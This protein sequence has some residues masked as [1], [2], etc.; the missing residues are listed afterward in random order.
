MTDEEIKQIEADLDELYN[1][2]KQL[3]PLTRYMYENN[4]EYIRFFGKIFG[5]NSYM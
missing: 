1:T 5:T 4:C 3:S 2:K